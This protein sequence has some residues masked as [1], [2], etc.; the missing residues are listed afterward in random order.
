MEQIKSNPFAGQIEAIIKKHEDIQDRTA[1]EQ[2]LKALAKEN[3]ITVN[4][5]LGG[6]LPESKTG[7]LSEEQLEE[8]S[9]GGSG[10]AMCV[11]DYRNLSGSNY[12]GPINRKDTFAWRDTHSKR[13]DSDYVRP[14]SSRNESIMCNWLMCRCYNTSHCDNYYHNC[15]EH[16][17]SLPFHGLTS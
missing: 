2:E 13:G 17:N 10:L 1:A 8:V 3:G 6:V 14:C 15:D 12:Q 7:E 9:G 16:G 4:K 11:F 5:L